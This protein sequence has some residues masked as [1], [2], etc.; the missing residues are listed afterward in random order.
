MMVKGCS[1]CTETQDQ[2][3]AEPRK[4]TPTP[5]LPYNMVGCDLFDFQLNKYVLLVDY[6]SN[7]IDVVELCSEITDWVIAAMKSVFTC[8]GIPCKL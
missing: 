1:K 4:P 3:C 8:H 7:S 5:D 2:Q 6:Y